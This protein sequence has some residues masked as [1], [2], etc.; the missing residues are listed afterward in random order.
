MLNFAAIRVQSQ[1]F[2]V[3]DLVTLAGMQPKD[4]GHFMNRNGFFNYSSDPHADTV[5]SFIPKIKRNKKDSV[6]QTNN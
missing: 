5:A 1:S 2:T 6:P 3:H 4:I